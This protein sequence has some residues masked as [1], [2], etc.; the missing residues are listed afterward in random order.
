MASVLES[1]VK[2]IVLSNAT[3]GPREI[4]QLVGAIH[5]DVTQFSFLRD[6]VAELEV[7][8][9]RSPAAAVR[10]GVCYFLLGRFV[11][12]EETLSSADGSALALFYLGKSQLAL[13][14]LVVAVESL[15]AAKKAGYDG[16]ETSLAIVESH[17]S[18]GMPD[19]A[20]SVLDTFLVRL[21]KPP[22]ICTSVVQL[23]PPGAATPKRSSRCM[24]GPLKP[25][26]IT[27]VRCLGWR[28][29][30]IGEVMIRMRWTCTSAPPIAFPRTLAR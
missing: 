15:E 17:R 25:M 11:R 1:E 22:N 30:M 20:M 6:A 28:L 2:D 29:K 8:E 3:F 12:A 27:Q 26:P 21:S 19:T 16:D 4:Q 10:L 18:Q 7:R 24:N 14:K 9:D 5:T 13:E 23:L